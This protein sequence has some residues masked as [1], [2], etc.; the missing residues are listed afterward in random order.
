TRRVKICGIRRPDDARLAADLG[1]SALGFIFW[2]GS[3][4]YIDP[5]RAKRIIAALPP[6]V[7]TVGVF[8][9]QPPAH[10]NGIA[11]LLNLS[12]IQLH[13]D[14]DPAEFMRTGARII[15]A[16]PVTQDFSDASL[17]AIPSDVT[18]LLDAHDPIRRGGTGRVV[19]WS[20]AARIAASRR[21]LLSGGLN[22]G[23][24]AEAIDQVRPYGVDVSSGVESSPGVK[25]A[26]KLRDLMARIRA[27]D[28]L[29]VK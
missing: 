4:R 22:A 9:N 21:T 1:V 15:K 16:V 3:P 23:N 19:D 2:P 12:A 11:R 10:A 7:S 26:T 28:R 25:D 17:A 8:V 29:E 27:T 13:G 5:F 6:F 20:I 14:E 18:V 24:I